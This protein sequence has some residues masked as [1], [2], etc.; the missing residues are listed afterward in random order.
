LLTLWF[1][2]SQSSLQ[3][4]Q[5]K[6]QVQEG[7]RGGPEVRGR[8]RLPAG[9]EQGGQEPAGTSRNQQ[10]YGKKKV[11][12]VILVF[13]PRGTERMTWRTFWIQ[14]GNFFSAGLAASV[15]ISKNRKKG[16]F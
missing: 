12:L 10:E 2:W 7:R 1:D 13:A 5:A 11:R 16:I 9:S 3:T 8:L 4:F 6:G 15:R 14:I